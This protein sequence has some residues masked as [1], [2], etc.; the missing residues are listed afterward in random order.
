M[1]SSPNDEEE[2][3]ILRADLAAALHRVAA[4]RPGRNKDELL[5]LGER[6]GRDLDAGE[7]RDVIRREVVGLYVVLAKLPRRRARGVP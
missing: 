4:F 3:E 6:L 1:G 5:A 2:L 7:A